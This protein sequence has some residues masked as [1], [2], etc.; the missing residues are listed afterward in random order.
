MEEAKHTHETYCGQTRKSW[1][2]NWELKLDPVFNEKPVEWQD[3]RSVWGKLRPLGNQ[4]GKLKE[5][6]SRKGKKEMKFLKTGTYTTVL[7]RL[8]I[9]QSYQL[10]VQRIYVCFVSWSK[11]KQKRKQRF[12]HFDEFQKFMTK[13]EVLPE[14]SEGRGDL[15]SLFHVLPWNKE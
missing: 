5:E 13:N 12:L 14:N 7:W 10:N 8:L 1:I 15:G 6:N 4:R 11:V 3:E 2:L 9:F